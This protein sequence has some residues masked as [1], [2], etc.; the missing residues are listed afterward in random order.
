MA[1][2]DRIL[3][4][5]GASARPAIDPMAALGS[6]AELRDRGAITE[7]EYEAKKQELLRRV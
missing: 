7:A 3:A 1:E 6:L 5:R 2:S 4:E